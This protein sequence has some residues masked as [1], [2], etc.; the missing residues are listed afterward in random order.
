MDFISKEDKQAIININKALCTQYRTTPYDL[1]NSKDVIELVKMATAE[2]CDISAYYSTLIDLDD[3]F[4]ATIE[5]FRPARWADMGTKGTTANKTLDNSIYN[6]EMTLDSFG[7]LH[8]EVEEK[9]IE[10]WHI[11]FNHPADKV[12][13]HYFGSS[14][15]YKAEKIKEAL[16][17]SKLFNGIE[18]DGVIESSITQFSLALKKELEN[19]SND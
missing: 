16:D 3:S 1:N 13:M 5:T 2:Y 11:A 6:L 18:Y 14:K 15:R 19:I 17:V 10:A 7:V 12:L 4:D 9:C 8:Q